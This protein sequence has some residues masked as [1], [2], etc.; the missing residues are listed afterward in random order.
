MP[1]SFEAVV[2]MGRNREIGVRNNLPWPRMRADMD[3]FRALTMSHPVI[4]GRNTWDSLPKPLLGRT[5]IVISRRAQ[6]IQPPGI[7]ALSFHEG[8]LEAI[9]LRVSKVF[10]IGGASM[11]EEAMRFTVQRLH[12]TVIDAN[13]SY[14]DRFFPEL[15]ESV[16]RLVRR[17]AFFADEKNPYPYSFLEFERREKGEVR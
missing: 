17:E 6:N 8:V 15:S 3:R 13:F 9:R 1:I 7:Q 16:W 12:V 5:N 11:Y 10:V 14:A 4:M 2:A